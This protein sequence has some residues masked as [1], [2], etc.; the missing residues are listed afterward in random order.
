MYVCV[1]PILVNRNDCHY[2]G[3]ATQ[4]VVHIVHSPWIC[5]PSPICLTD[6][7]LF[8]MTSHRTEFMELLWSYCCCNHP[9]VTLIGCKLISAL[10]PSSRCPGILRYWRDAVGG[11]YSW[12]VSY[13]NIDWISGH[14]LSRLRGIPKYV[15]LKLC[16]QGQILMADIRIPTKCLQALR[17]WTYFS[18]ATK[19]QHTRTDCLRVLN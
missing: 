17:R 19:H 4:Y 18:I 3:T 14:P 12:T 6:A 5:H 8:T 16:A 9:I 7:L 15:I 2:S 11:V 1:S 10:L 13:Y